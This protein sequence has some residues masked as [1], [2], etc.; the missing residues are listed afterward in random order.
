MLSKKKK[1][2]LVTLPTLHQVYSVT[3]IKR[4]ILLVDVS[5][6]CALNLHDLLTVTQSVYSHC[7]PSH[8]SKREITHNTSDLYCDILDGWLEEVQN[9]RR[10]TSG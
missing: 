5:R 6:I 4:N 10:Y 3:E 7:I 8:T 9:D 1:N 2:T